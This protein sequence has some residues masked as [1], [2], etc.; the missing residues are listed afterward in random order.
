M[1]T[2]NLLIDGKSLGSAQSLQVINPADESVVTSCPRGTPT[3]LNEAVA[4]AKRAFPAWS[5]TPYEYRAAVLA[6]LADRIDEHKEDIARF[7][8][9]EQGKPIA[10]ARDEVGYAA[11]FCR[12]FSGFRFDPEVIQDDA[13][14]RVEVHRRPLGVVAAIVP[15]NFPFLQAAYK[16]APALLMG[17]TVVLKP[18]PTTPLT[19]LLLGEIL[20]DLVPPGVFNVVTDGGD[21][22]PLLSAHPDVAKVSFTGSTK[23]GREVMAA[24]ASTLKHLTLELG[25]NDAAIVLDDV[26]VK[27]VAP[28]IFGGAFFNSGQVCIAIKRIYVQESIYDAFC[29]E[30][31]R[32]AASAV[33]GNGLDPATEFGP[34]Q[35]KNQFDRVGG[36]L[37][38]ARHHGRII[39]GGE[40]YGPGYFVRP[41]IVRDIAEGNSLV[42]E[43]TFGPVRS[44]LKFKTVDE[45]I[46]RANNTQY[47]LGGSVWSKNIARAK[48]IAGRLECGTAW[49][50]QHL[51]FGPHIPFGG[52]KQ[53]GLGIEFSKE[54]VLEFTDVQVISIAKS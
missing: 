31:G 10:T 30:L 34:L 51:G 46:A 45:V 47:G 14:Q 27:E 19:S 12:H 44:V 41:T 7:L 24:A 39:A 40:S 35:N 29:D 53:S 48:E 33:V 37:E 16:T 26:D 42:D 6:K 18:A 54:G 17:N 23:V 13:V 28:K 9:L 20:G 22:G 15:W 11:I 1:R 5:A 49:V 3:L 2:F 25:G 36:Y 43:E 21:L 52:I 50:N 4:A 32:I 8:T 38:L